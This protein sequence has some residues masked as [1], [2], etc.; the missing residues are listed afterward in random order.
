MGSNISRVKGEIAR[1]YYGR[2]R[3][4]GLGVGMGRGGGEVV[5]ELWDPGFGGGRQY[6]RK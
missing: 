4:K 6:G 5:G 2:E 1:G 3:E